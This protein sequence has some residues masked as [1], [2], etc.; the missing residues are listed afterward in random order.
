[1]TQRF[2]IALTREARK[3]DRKIDLESKVV[4]VDGVRVVERAVG[5]KSLTVEIPTEL[6]WELRARLPFAIVE[7]DVGLSLL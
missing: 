4:E 6:V 3:A 2:V 5:G 7:P 1:M